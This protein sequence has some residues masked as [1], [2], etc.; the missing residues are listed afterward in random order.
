MTK[1]RGT[2]IILTGFMGT[3]KTVIG[4]LVAAQLGWP[5]VDTDLEIEKQSGLRIAEIFA[6]EGEAAFRDLE[7]RVLQQVLQRD[8]VVIATGGGAIVDADNR[9]RMKRDSWLVCLNAPP[10]HIYQRLR[11]TGDR[12]LLK[13]R[14]PLTEIRRLLAERRPFY[15]EAH[16]VIE[17]AHKEESEIA[18]EILRRFRARYPGETAP[19]PL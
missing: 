6:E 14:D 9:T 18:Q 7:K 8:Q 13:V 12:P 16:D 10:E 1:Q 17:T 15:E 3:G 4:R 2:R 19:E 5:F 11:E